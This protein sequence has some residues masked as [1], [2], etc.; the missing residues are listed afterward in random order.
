MHRRSFISMGL[1]LS[2]L[3]C[4]CATR[5]QY[6]AVECPAPKEKPIASQP[7]PAEGEVSQWIEDA[8]SGQP[9]KQ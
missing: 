5:V 1:P 2:L 4:S 7:I 3:L 8:I 9:S 6:A